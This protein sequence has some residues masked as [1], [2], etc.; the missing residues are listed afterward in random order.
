MCNIPSKVD[1][2]P[3]GNDSSSKGPNANRLVEESQE[4][5]GRAGG[6]LK[7]IISTSHDRKKWITG[8][9]K[10]YFLRNRE[11]S[12]SILYRISATSNPPPED[13]SGF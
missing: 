11:G 12:E 9:T 4:R 7:N 5:P 3:T 13:T 6:S 10:V 2:F 8:K 1:S